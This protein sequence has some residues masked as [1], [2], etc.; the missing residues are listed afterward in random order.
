[1]FL[2][3]T[4]DQRFWKL[5]KKILFLGE[6]CK[7]YRYRQSIAEL[8]YETVSYHWANRDKL[9]NDFHYLQAI[10]ESYLLDLA[11]Q[12]NKIH[13]VNFSLKFWRIVIGPWLSYFIDIFFDRYC[14]IINAT[15]HHVITDSYIIDPC[16]E[17]KF[18]PAN[19]DQFT[20]WMQEDLYNQFL[21]S[22][23]IKKSNIPYTIKGDI[24]LDE[25]KDN[26]SQLSFFRKKGRR[27]LR[28]LI[29]KLINYLSFDG[30][31]LFF[32]STQFTSYNLFKIQIETKQIKSSS[33]FDSQ[34][35]IYKT[36]ID[37][38][39]KISL[40]R[41]NH[42]FEELLN[43][44]IPLQIPISYIEGFKE[45]NKNALKYYPYKPNVIISSC[46]EVDNDTFKIWAAYHVETSNSR[47]NI[48]QHGGTYG[49]S[50][51]FSMEDHF[52]K[53]SDY[54]YSWGWGGSLS[55]E[56]G[57]KALPAPKLLRVKKRLKPN[58]TGRILHVSTSFPRYSYK[59]YSG[60][61]SSTM[62][63]YFD[64]EFC[65]VDKLS[66]DV[67]KL[68]L[69]RLYP[70]NMGWDEELRWK[71]RFPDLEIYQG[72]NKSFYT[73][74]NKSRLSIHTSNS[75]TFL[76]TLSANFPSLII[77]D[78]NL[79]E[80]NS[81]AKKYFDHLQDVG[82]FHTSPITAAQTVN[83]IFMSPMRW[84]FTPKRQAAKNKFCN[85]F[86][87]TKDDWLPI[88]KNELLSQLD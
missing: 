82:I 69:V 12:L 17:K 7:L 75:T 85:Q 40:S 59:L 2:V 42:L 54:F 44:I 70:V 63:D 31:K 48:I 20:M 55:D 61:M 76:E 51:L 33:Q 81:S 46:S 56:K 28:I 67:K 21:Y 74:C 62:L 19:M 60:P 25:E 66:D 13:G 86:A 27:V 35:D 73:Q 14:S 57:T 71:D 29:D 5:N 24:S 88:W 84:W 80:I 4:A 68:L 64:W 32:V 53:I 26:Y 38:R 58:P 36:N 16:L 50:K 78:T 6:W 52:L 79:W 8:S 43:E 22:F 15:K 49:M 72:R 87:L 23:L 9:Y 39:R 34:Q 3:T 77:W 10:Y 11:K 47:L 18:I 45:I 30:Q 1:M 41:N 65:F 83:D 37:I